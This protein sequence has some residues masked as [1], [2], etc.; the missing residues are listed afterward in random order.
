MH[1]RA[2]TLG[3][4]VAVAMIIGLTAGCSAPASFAQRMAFLQKVS[5]EGVETHRLIVSQGGTT[6]TKRCTD[7]YGGLSDPSIPDDQA[8]GEAP[9]DAWLG[10]I[11]SFYVES[12]VTGLPQA[13]PGVPTSSPSGSATA[14]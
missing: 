12:C 4:A 13:V 8:D 14:S 6:T 5:N 2:T 9:S 10:Q 7:A 11:Q 1:V 3:S